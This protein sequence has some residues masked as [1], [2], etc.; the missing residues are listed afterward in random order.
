MVDRVRIV[1]GD[2]VAAQLRELLAT[3]PADAAD[4]VEQHT[5]L[6]KSDA[7]SRVGLLQ[8]QQQQYCLKLYLAR[9]ARQKLLYRLGRGRPVRGFEVARELAAAN[10]PVPAARACLA[11][12]QGLLLLTEGIVDAVNLN[13]LWRQ[14]SARNDAGQVLHCAAQSIAQLHRAGYAHGDCKWSNLL[15]TG[16]RVYLVDLDG[17]GKAAMGSAGQ[18]RDLARFTLNAE[19]WALSPQLYRRFLQSYLRGTGGSQAQVVASMLPQLHRLRARHLA[20]Y[21]ERGQ[22]LF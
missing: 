4:W 9:S 17:A 11:V 21:G 12:P 18:A 20:K 14:Q 13:D 19:E 8:L 16:E 5:H 15:W 1:R 3:P 2:T 22:R 7:N 10:L 6:L